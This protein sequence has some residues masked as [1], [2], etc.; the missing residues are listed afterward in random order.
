MLFLLSS[1]AGLWQQSTKYWKL[2]TYMC[3]VLGFESS[4]PTMTKEIGKSLLLRAATLTKIG[5]YEQ[6]LGKY[7]EAFRLFL[8]A[9][10]HHSNTNV[11][12]ASRIRI[13]KDI[14]YLL[15]SL[16]S[17]MEI[18][19]HLGFAS[20][21]WETLQLI[22]NISSEVH[23]PAQEF[24]RFIMQMLMFYNTHIFSKL[25]EKAELERII[26][27]MYQQR[28]AP[29]L[30]I[31][32][33]DPLVQSKAANPV[34]Q[35]KVQR[36]KPAKDSFYNLCNR[37]SVRR[38]E[39]TKTVL[40]K[41]IGF[42][43][44]KLAEREAERNPHKYQDYTE[45]EQMELELNEGESHIPK[46]DKFLDTVGQLNPQLRSRSSSVSI[47]KSLVIPNRVSKSKDR[48]G[49]SRTYHIRQVDSLLKLTD[50]SVNTSEEKH[51]SLVPSLYLKHDEQ[52]HGKHDP[53]SVQNNKQTASFRLKGLLRES[54]LSLAVSRSKHS[55]HR[56]RAATHRDTHSYIK[57]EESVVASQKTP[58]EISFMRARHNS[59]AKQ[60]VRQEIQV[61][62]HGK[63][64]HNVEPRNYDHDD[65]MPKP[66]FDPTLEGFTK[67]VIL[68]RLKEPD[69]SEARSVLQRSKIVQKKLLKQD[70]QDRRL[71]RGEKSVIYSHRVYP[72]PIEEDIKV[73]FGECTPAEMD[74]SFQVSKVTK[75]RYSQGS[76]GRRVQFEE[77]SAESPRGVSAERRVKA[78]MSS[79]FSKLWPGIMRASSNVGSSHRLLAIMAAHPDTFKIKKALQY[80]KEMIRTPKLYEHELRIRSD[81]VNRIRSKSEAQ[82]VSEANERIISNMETL[83][84]S[85]KRL[86]Q[87][88]RFMFSG[89]SITDCSGSQHTREVGP[90][91]ERCADLA[92]S[93]LS[94][95]LTQR[96]LD[97]EKRNLHKQ[98]LLQRQDSD[99]SS[100]A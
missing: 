50:P 15:V 52:H 20:A 26:T 41:L 2:N 49:P 54:A 94:A 93:L 91:S 67:K 66:L 33:E 17:I 78:R 87:E 95:R 65:F 32:V 56:S 85:K 77:P 76:A 6:A 75:G 60:S 58:Q 9:L 19:G 40:D 48:Q 38:P 27:T 90:L 30:W 1:N 55:S 88:L 89:K 86:S 74:L 12:V 43:N 79:H 68:N 22:A 28:F 73:D 61:D 98:A 36:D 34:D 96:R 29:P 59:S 70:V 7:Y 62:D 71:F 10:S 83:E 82:I 23:K 63:L 53:S 45:H 24:S 46:M 35:W 51:R 81:L 4:N 5:E 31:A 3:E 14:D 18:L 97:V 69:V 25:N 8:M 13:M 11:W 100:E 37:K 84:E 92:T 21:A 64:V 80:R 42:E 99:D 72:T 47:Q 39:E 57:S 16:I 44:E